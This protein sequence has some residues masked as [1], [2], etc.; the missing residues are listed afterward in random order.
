MKL[1]NYKSKDI[2][3]EI[4]ILKNIYKEIFDDKSNIFRIYFNLFFFLSKQTLTMQMHGNSGRRNKAR[5]GRNVKYSHRVANAFAYYG[6]RDTVLR[7]T[8]RFGGR[9]RDC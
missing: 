1:N 6:N 5:T 2:K 9:I 8:I 4:K 7:K 3:K